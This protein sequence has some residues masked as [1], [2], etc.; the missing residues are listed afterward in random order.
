M[1][2]M[3]IDNPLLQTYF[4]LTQ[5]KTEDEFIHIDLGILSF[6]YMKG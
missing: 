4:H 3:S 1:K 2:S 5:K 6:W